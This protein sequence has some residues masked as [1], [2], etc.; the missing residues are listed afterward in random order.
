MGSAAAY[1][2]ARR[3]KRVLGLERFTP[4]HDRGASQGRSRIIREAYWEHPS[5]VP[6]V[7]RSYELWA[8]LEQEIGRLLL[9]TT[10][11]LM[12]GAPE[13]DLIKGT[14][15]SARTYD[16]KHE[17]LDA[18]EITRR[19]SV[20]NPS[21]DMVGVLESRA[22]VLFPEECV[23]AHLQRAAAHGADLRYEEPVVNWSAE[24]GQVMVQTAEARYEAESLV[25]TPGPW[26]PEV[27][28]ELHLPLVIE[29]QVVAWFRP[30]TL[31]EAFSPDRCPVYI[32]QTNRRLFYGFPR[33]GDA[34]VKI[35][36]HAL[37]DPTTADTIRRQIGPE[38]IEEIRR[39]FIARHMPAA[40]GPVL[41]THTCM[42][43][44]TPDTHFIIDRYPQ[45]SNVV[46]ACG[47]SGHGFKFTPV[48]GEILAD[49]VLE[50]RTAHDISLFS[51]VRLNGG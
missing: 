45:Q 5:Y 47:F 49:L 12:V 10:G 9:L 33:L 42:Y 32:W 6:L 7:W 44:M 2:L 31:L 51:M 16:L 15:L 41:A 20:F 11:G 18:Q 24:G 35:A 39:D 37:G 8:D 29:R 23:L 4:G 36:E 13:S 17:V 25:L 14:L 40:N 1:H 43:T 38:E 30:L 26:A 21:N 46:L 19:F 48:V 22:G 3:G 28:T 34:G 50:G 27:L